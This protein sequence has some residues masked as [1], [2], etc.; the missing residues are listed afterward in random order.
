MRG[1]SALIGALGAAVVGTSSGKCTRACN[2]DTRSISAHFGDK[3]ALTKVA[4]Y[5]SSNR[6]LSS[7]RGRF[8]SGELH[9]S[10][11]Y[12]LTCLLSGRS[13]APLVPKHVSK[14][15]HTIF[16]F[17]NFHLGAHTTESP[18]NGT[19]TRSTQN[20]FGIKTFL[21]YMLRLRFWS[22]FL[23]CTRLCSPLS[24]MFS[25]ERDSRRMVHSTCIR[26]VTTEYAP[27]STPSSVQVPPKTKRAPSAVSR[28]T[29]W[30][31][32]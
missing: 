1:G 11:K 22:T 30:T 5:L 26:Q 27:I 3:H 23:V 8:F 4:M 10:T 6:R 24:A 9:S 18:D 14:I 28:T 15:A 32:C 2:S 12:P 29:S 16:H 21:Q 19:N 31:E 25:F 13:S 17:R 7:K 20:A